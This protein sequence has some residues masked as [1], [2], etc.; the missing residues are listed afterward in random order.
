MTSFVGNNAPNMGVQWMATISGPVGTGIGSPANLGWGMPTLS[1]YQY[2]LGSPS[3]MDREIQTAQQAALLTS[4]ACLTVAGGLVVMQGVIAADTAAA[5]ASIKAAT[6][7]ETAAA[8]QAAAA[9][10]ITA[11][12]AAAAASAKASTIGAVLTW[13]TEI[14]ASL[15]AAIMG[16]AVASAQGNQSLWAIFQINIIALKDELNLA[17]SVLDS[18]I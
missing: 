2:Y 3:Q 16:A 11:A 17:T 8:A 4:A 13:M 12:Q 14:R 10:A 6:A 18:L 15:N 9:E 1:N 5:A 7:A